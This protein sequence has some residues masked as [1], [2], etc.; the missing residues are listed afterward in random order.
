MFWLFATLTMI[1]PFSAILKP[2]SLDFYYIIWFTFCESFAGCFSHIL[3]TLYPKVTCLIDGRVKSW[4][5]HLVIWFFLFWIHATT[6]HHPFLHYGQQKPRQT[7]KISESCT[8][9]TNP[10]YHNFFGYPP[11]TFMLEIC[12]LCS[13]TIFGHRVNIDLDG[14]I[15]LEFPPKPT[16]KHPQKSKK[17]L[18]HHNS[19]C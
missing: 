9:E 19:H 13:V 14:I 3:K 12:K 11:A 1:F 15:L 7:C 16:S 8:P 6:K 5:I 17:N 4:C 18:L 10:F 2:A